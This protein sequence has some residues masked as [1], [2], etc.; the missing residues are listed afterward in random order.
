MLCRVAINFSVSEW[1][2]ISYVFSMPPRKS[3]WIEL[4]ESKGKLCRWIFWPKL[5]LTCFKC[6]LADIVKVLRV[7]AQFHGIPACTP[8]RI[9]DN[10][11]IC[12]HNKH[13]NPY[14]NDVNKG[15]YIFY[16]VILKTVTQDLR[17]LSYDVIKLEFFKSRSLSDISVYLICIPV[18]WRT[19]TTL[20]F[21][22][23]LS[24]PKNTIA[25][26]NTRLKKKSQD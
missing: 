3:T 26:K 10:S 18:Q 15:T 6:A 13:S 9:F 8:R 20:V 14:S 19:D 22:F 16:C 1:Y 23:S 2:S 17:L 25:R 7:L 4:R 5:S 12:R 24:T 11:I 21:F